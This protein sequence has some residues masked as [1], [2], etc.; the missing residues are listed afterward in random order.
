[1]IVLGVGTNTV[2]TDSY[3]ELIVLLLVFFLILFAAYYV[4]KLIAKKGLLR[5]K[6]QNIELIESF[7]L[8]QN[9]MI[10]IVRI[11]NKYIVIGVSKDHFE[12]LTEVDPEELDLTP[13]EASNKDVSFKE[14]IQNVVKGQKNTA[15]DGNSIADIAG[16][17]EDEED[18]EA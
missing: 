6:T 15:R 11:G 17:T 4:T 2:V 18:K 8:N 7:R 5:G 3:V 16:Y 9:K 12:Y 1:M 14:V 10:Q 13:V